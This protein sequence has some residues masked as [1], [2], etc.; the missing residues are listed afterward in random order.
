MGLA[1]PSTRTGT[2]TLRPTSAK[3]RARRFTSEA[4][5]GKTVKRVTVNLSIRDG[6]SWKPGVRITKVTNA[7]GL[8]AAH[9]IGDAEKW[10]KANVRK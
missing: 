10:I 7:W 5:F 6:A 1:P 9:V 2:F 4:A 3:V 8:S